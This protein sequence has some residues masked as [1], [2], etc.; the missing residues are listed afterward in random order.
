[1]WPYRAGGH[2][3]CTDDT[4]KEVFG[5]GSNTVVLRRP[6]LCNAG[7]GHPTGGI[8]IARANVQWCYSQAACLAWEYNP[9]QGLYLDCVLPALSA[10]DK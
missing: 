10:Q 7:D 8:G 4:A 1:M 5:L 6:T 3:L 2:L 9:S